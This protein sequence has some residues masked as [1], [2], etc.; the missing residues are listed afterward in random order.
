MS[1]RERFEKLLAKYPHPH[2]NF[3]QRPHFTRRNFFNVVGAGVA[4]SYLA[5]QVKAA[6]TA[7]N[8][9]VK[10][11]N[12]AKNVI[13]VLLAGAPSHVDTFDFKN[14]SGTTP[15]EMAPETINGITLPTGIFP[16]LAQ[17]NIPDL[18]IVRSVRSWALVHQLAQTWSQIGRNPA[19]ALGNIA[20]NIGSVVAIEKDGERTKGQVFPTFLALNSNGAAGPGYFESKFAPFKSTPAASGLA[21]TTNTVGQTR[22]NDMYA[23]LRADDDALRINSPLGKNVEDMD[24]FYNSARGLMYN[25]TVNKAF[26]FTAAD[27]ARYGGTGFGNACLVARQTMAAGQGTRFI[28]ITFG[29]W[30]MHQN[31]YGAN[32]NIA[33][34]NNIFTMGKQ[35]DNGLS[36]MLSDMKA[37]GTL[38]DTLVVVVGEFGRTVGPIT[39]QGGRDHF[40]QQFA[41]FAGGGVKGGRALG[42]TKADGSATLDPGW[43]RQRDVRPEDIEA[44]IYSALGINWTTIR[45]DDPF[46]RGFEYVPNSKDDLYGPINEL[47]A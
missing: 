37:D 44:T 15:K 9:D 8:P 42:S 29:S 26:G 41:L 30:D 34:G 22:A 40:L 7:W 6:E 23:T 46:G 14:F 2:R 47:W 18:A 5:G 36:A 20:P 3:F 32:G 27:S 13:F 17:N 24:D 19:A 28:Q 39:A 45:Y 10:T 11:L 31:I 4:G 25:P 12:T 33:A 21:N 43:S 16:N 35:L 1:E 38:A